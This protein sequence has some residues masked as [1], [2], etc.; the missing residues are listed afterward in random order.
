MPWRKQVPLGPP[1]MLRADKIDEEHLKAQEL[2]CAE[3]DQDYFKHDIMC[4]FCERGAVI[5]RTTELR[6]THKCGATN[7]PKYLC[8]HC[9]PYCTKGH[10][11]TVP[12]AFI[13]AIQEIKDDVE[14]RS[15]NDTPP[16]PPQ[17]CA[18]NNVRRLQYGTWQATLLHQI[19]QRELPAH[20]L[21]SW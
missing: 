2:H 17:V 7:P 16:P 12:V 19:L 15:S 9:Y 3:H 1:A 20:R 6:G 18:S 8:C 10:N 5:L 13:R 14:K 4:S 21:T 11:W